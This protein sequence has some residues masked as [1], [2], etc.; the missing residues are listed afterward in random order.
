ME[1]LK[2]H[3]KKYESDIVEC[4]FTLEAH[5]KCTEE[6]ATE[7]VTFHAPWM[8]ERMIKMTQ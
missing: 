1:E 6:D 4:E 8:I 7:T 3:E 2:Y 5:K